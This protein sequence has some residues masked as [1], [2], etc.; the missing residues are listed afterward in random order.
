VRIHSEAL[1]PGEQTLVFCTRLRFRKS[2]KVNRAGEIPLLVRFQLLELL[3]R[4]LGETHMS[5][6]TDIEEGWTTW[7]LHCDGACEQDCPYCH[8]TELD[9]LPTR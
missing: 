1:I 6:E 4:R 3:D 2:D 7:Q 5:E 8:R 9:E